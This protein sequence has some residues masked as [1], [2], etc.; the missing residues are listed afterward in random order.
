MIFLLVVFFLSGS[1]GYSQSDTLEVQKL[2]DAAY[3][4]E[5]SNPDSAFGLYQLAFDLS[6]EIDYQVGEFR[7]LQ[8]TGLLYSD[9]GHYEKAISFFNKSMKYAQTSNFKLGIA[10]NYI[11]IGNVHMYTGL[12]NKAIESYILGVKLFEEIKDSARL[13]VSY[14][15]LASL[16]NAIKKHKEEE[17]FL[18]KALEWTS[19]NDKDNR[20][21]VYSD[22]CNTAL[23]NKSFSKAKKYAN[24]AK[25]LL[26]DISDPTTR[27]HVLKGL[28]NYYGTTGKYKTSIA[29]FLK[30]LLNIDHK[31]DKFFEGEI[32]FSIG[33]QYFNLSN[34][35]TALDYALKSFDVAKSIDAMDQQKKC[36]FLISQ[37]YKYTQNYKKAYKFLE[38]SY[39]LKDSLFNTQYINKISTLEKKFEIERKDKEIAGQQLRIK[40][41][42]LAIQL[43]DQA[44]YK[45]LTIALIS[46]LGMV[47]LFGFYTTKQ[48]INDKE[49]EALKAKHNLEKLTSLIEGE[50]KERQRLAQDLHDGINGMLSAIKYRV[51]TFKK[52]NFSSE[53]VADIDCTASMLDSAI[54]QVRI[55]SHNLTPPAI[56]S[57]GYIHVIK[58]YCDSIVADRDI[59]LFF[60]SYGP[61]ASLS[62]NAE[63]AIYRIVQELLNNVIKH[64]K[65][66]EI[67]VQ[68]NHHVDTINITIQDNGVGFDVLKEYSGI[69]I[70]NI[71]SRVDFL[72][73]KFELES[74]KEGTTASLLIN[75]ENLF[76]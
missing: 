9:L 1:I 22:L 7:A 45:T 42:E 58:N 67:I 3:E 73:A 55:I 34:Y 36:A 35:K 43:K 39:H 64:A 12:Y 14:S 57:N 53:E 54:E 6:K 24:N 71:N 46:L 41:Q 25:S 52:K 32:L 68:I 27:L 5:V 75:K 17:L 21:V 10:S 66:T 65:A 37:I 16:Y 76:I 74:S 26:V 51:M 62:I 72:N 23:K 69:G 40:D 47:I 20:A 38:T 29:Y 61:P 63:T 30:S 31:N 56:N 48:K 60:Q 28:G 2:L 59:K 49:M 8:Y 44:Y 13:S 15:N 11:N 4:K 19:L 18:T 70:R 33:K 50:E